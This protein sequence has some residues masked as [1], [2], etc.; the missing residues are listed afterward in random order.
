[1]KEIKKSVFF[2]KDEKILFCHFDSENYFSNEHNSA[3]HNEYFEL[4]W[5]KKFPVQFFKLT[6]L[7]WCV[8]ET[9]MFIE[10]PWN[11]EILMN[12]WFAH[13]IEK[14][15]KFWRKKK[16]IHCPLNRSGQENRHKYPPNHCG[17]RF[18]SLFYQHNSIFYEIKIVTDTESYEL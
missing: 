1:M 3:H 5:K 17:I 7:I 6:E 15:L 13:L 9:V 4:A 14:Y 18:L 10:V 11:D 2:S 12:I 8:A 16:S